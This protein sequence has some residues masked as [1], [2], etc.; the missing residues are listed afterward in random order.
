MFKKVIFQADQVNPVN[1]GNQ[2]NPGK[3]GGDK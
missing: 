1:Q 3:K 2:V